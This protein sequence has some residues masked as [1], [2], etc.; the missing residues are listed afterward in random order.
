MAIDVSKE[1]KVQVTMK[2]IIIQVITQTKGNT[3]YSIMAMSSE[4]FITII[5]IYN[6][7]SSLINSYEFPLTR[8][9]LL[10]L[11]PYL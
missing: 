4:M 8:K 11:K 2:T 1:M 9:N 10:T 5:E 3:H 6:L 7:A